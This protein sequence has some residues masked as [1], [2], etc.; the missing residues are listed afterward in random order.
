MQ[1]VLISELQKRYYELTTVKPAAKS[2]PSP[3]ANTISDLKPPKREPLQKNI[4][5]LNDS[6]SPVLVCAD[7]GAE[8]SFI[9]TAVLD[10]AGV[11]YCWDELPDGPCVRG[12]SSTPQQCKII[13]MRITMVH[14][15]K[16]FSFKASLCV[17]KLD[18]YRF[19]MG[20]DLLVPL[21]YEVSETGLKLTN[22]KTG[23]STLFEFASDSV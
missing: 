6:S 14:P 10:A 3:Q 13:V 20:R 2:T 17:A 1:K 19:L 4:V 21:K 16:S 7:T 9:S 23:I 18:A 22:P 5:Y 12:I 15:T 8:V 11:D